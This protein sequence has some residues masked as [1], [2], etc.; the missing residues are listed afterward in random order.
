MQLLRDTAGNVSEAARRAGMAGPGSAHSSSRHRI[1]ANDVQP[2]LRW[3]VASVAEIVAD[4]HP[5]DVVAM[6]QTVQ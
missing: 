2:R 1:D 6:E 5:A 4:S 3:M